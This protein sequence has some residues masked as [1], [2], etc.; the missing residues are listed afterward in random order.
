MTGFHSGQGCFARDTLVGCHM[1]QQ[2]ATID[3][4]RKDAV[5]QHKAKH[6][7]AYYEWNHKRNEE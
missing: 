1:Q 4:L 6:A 3:L 7:Y 5:W 2:G